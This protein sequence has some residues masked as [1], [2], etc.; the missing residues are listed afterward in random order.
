MLAL[1]RS[2]IIFM[3]AENKM[4]VIPKESFITVDALKG[5]ANYNDYVFD[6]DTMEYILLC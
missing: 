2:E 3:N 5:I 4:V 1:T 6:I